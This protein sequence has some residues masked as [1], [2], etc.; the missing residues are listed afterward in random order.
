VQGQQWRQNADTRKTRTQCH[1]VCVS[2]R[3]S[4]QR[5][6][7]KGKQ[8]RASRVNQI[9]WSPADDK[10]F[11]AQEEALDSIGWCDNEQVGGLCGKLA[12]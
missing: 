11:C 10:G 6:G 9:N 5:R 1:C 12:S 8:S 3:A 4:Q 2:F 7:S